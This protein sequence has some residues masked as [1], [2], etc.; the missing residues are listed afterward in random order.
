M[1]YSKIG[2]Y[3]GLLV[4]LVTLFVPTLSAFATD[5]SSDNY[6]VTDTEFGS[7]AELDSCSGQ[8]CAKTSIGPLSSDASSSPSSSVDFGM[9]ASDSGPLL[10][11][12]VDQGESNLGVLSTDKTATKTMVV[13][14]RTYLSDGYTLQINGS[15][16]KYKDYSLHTSSTATESQAGVELFGINAVANTSPNIGKNPVL[17]PEETDATSLVMDGYKTQNYFKYVDGGIVAKNLRETSQAEYTISMVVNI[18]GS[19][20]AGHFSA[21]FSAVVVPVF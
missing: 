13:K 14:V 6:Q 16:P 18:S 7:G 21:D 17:N 8:Y 15:P 10:E 1:E 5:S 4:L 3:V 2:R 11:V 9:I 19:T 12:I 20:P